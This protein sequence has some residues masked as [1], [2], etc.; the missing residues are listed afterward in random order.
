MFLG[1]KYKVLQLLFGSILAQEIFAKLR[2]GEFN[3]QLN[4]IISET[5]PDLINIH[6]LHSASL[7][8]SLIQTSLKFSPVVWTLHDCWSFSGAYYP[9]HCPSPDRFQERQ[10]S[11]FWQTIKQQGLNDR[12]SA[13]APSKWLQKKALASKW[14]GTRVESIHNPIPDFFFEQRDRTA[15]KK[16]LGLSNDKTIILCIAG[17]LTEERKGGPILKQLLQ[18]SQ[19][20]NIQFL[21]V[22]EKINNFVDSPKIRQL[23]F[24]SDDITLRMIYN[25]ADILLHPAPIDN[26]PNTVAESMSCG[27]P[28]LAF[29]TG[30]L[31]EMVKSGKSGWLVDTI[32]AKSMIAKIVR[33]LNSRSYA[34]IRKS[35][36]SHAKSL[37]DSASVGKSY[38]EH[39]LTM[40]KNN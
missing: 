18:S 6:N 17:N 22:G 2:E 40:S 5:K 7:P 27:T 12:L 8:I 26:L 10:I 1:K 21:L 28:V 37:F 14:E 15:C 33:I 23:G 32:D 38:L 3:R 11:D 25:A 31:P 35:T 4:L 30:G 16:A 13:I 9:T 34:C 19:L 20:E 36:K 24:V 29:T 39:F